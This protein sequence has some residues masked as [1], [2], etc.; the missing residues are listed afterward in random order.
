MTSR[1]GGSFHGWKILYLT[2]LGQMVS[3]SFTIS[4]IGIFIEP[5]AQAFSATPG[6]L[7]WAPAIFILMGS[8]LSPLVGYFIDRGHVR[9]IMTMGSILFALGFFALSQ[10]TTLFQAALACSL[11]LGCGSSMIGFVAANALLVQWFNRR[12]G[13]AIGV[14]AAGMSLGGFL[15]PPI[16]AELLTHFD[17]RITMFLLGSFVTLTLVP[18]VWFIARSKPADL[19]QYPDGIAPADAAASAQA[20]AQEDAV[21]LGFNDLLRRRDFWIIALAMATVNFSS[22]MLITYLVPFAR[23][24]GM[25]VPSSALLLSYY[26][27]AAFVGKFLAGWLNDRFSPRRV[28]SAIC[29][30]MALG[31]YLQLNFPAYLPLVVA[32]TGLAVGGIMPVWAT[33]IGE[34]F[35]PGA[36]GKAQGGMALILMVFNV[37]PGPLGGHLYD[38]TGTYVSGFEL[39][40][41]VL[42]GGFA[43]SCLLP[44]AKSL[45]T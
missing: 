18:S 6:Q 14:S 1:S 37:I 29:I 9:V 17:W 45:T 44:K 10:A 15:V 11:L 8:I 26:S 24:T 32:L 25:S 35:G 43:I 23:E 33:L 19:G 22:I 38:S 34:A 2:S 13:F 20:G 5:L 31:V 30:V 40:I 42:I 39:I 12:R 4:L 41:W 7:G 3:S 28:F 36:F 21:A 27:G 16:A